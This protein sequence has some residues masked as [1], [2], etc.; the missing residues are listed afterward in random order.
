MRPKIK[1]FIPLRFKISLLL[2]LATNLMALAQTDPEIQGKQFFEN[3][4][5]AE[6][7]P[8]FEDLVRL[9]PDDPELNYYLGACLIE[10]ENYS[11]QAQAALQLAEKEAKR[12]WYLAQYYHA[13]ARWP[14]ATQ[15]YKTFEQQASSKERKSVPLDEMLALCEDE[16][17]PFATAEESAEPE[18]VANTTKTESLPETPIAAP[19]P[20]PVSVEA[21]QYADSLINFPVNAQISYLKIDQFKT[22]EG[23]SA[24][25]K[26]LELQAQLDSV[27][28][29]SRELRDRYDKADEV[30]KAE[31]VD[32]ILQLEQ[33]SYQLNQELAQ[34]KQT[35]N[36]LE[37]AYWTNATMEERSRFQKEVQAIR[38][39]IQQAEIQQQQTLAIEETAEV[40]I[41]EPTDSLAIDTLN[42]ATD[43]EPVDEIFYRIQIGAYRNDPPDW[44]QRLYKKLGVLRRIDQYTDE[45][46]I[47][48]Y[49]VGKLKT[50][51]DAQQMLKQI[52]LEGVSTAKIAAYK[53]G[54]RIPVAEARKLE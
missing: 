1:S 15:E 43:A 29:A 16:V 4:Q 12:H 11:D 17:N 6:A 30:Q 24:F 19:A 22:P 34:Q 33:Q 28:N 44:V 13:H 54:D 32:S 49:T 14:E 40:L 51:E 52:K 45:D 35:A 10:T 18:P 46:G 38:D 31:L 20:T 42:I 7:L 53:N 26:S 2:L 47:T 25:I 9:Y 3:G 48:V 39:S 37:V 41:I 27:L 8:L 50:Y 21:E 36:Q 5:Y 23:Q